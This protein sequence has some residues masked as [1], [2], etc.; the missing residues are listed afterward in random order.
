MP[1]KV[2]KKAQHLSSYFTQIESKAEKLRQHVDEIQKLILTK[3]TVGEVTSR[4]SINLIRFTW[5]PM[6]TVVVQK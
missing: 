4:S 3:A 5:P 2:T 6:P 1:K